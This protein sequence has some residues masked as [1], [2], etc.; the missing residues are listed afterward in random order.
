L[1]R[2]GSVKPVNMVPPMLLCATAYLTAYGGGDMRY[3]YNNARFSIQGQPYTLS[4]GYDVR[5]APTGVPAA[6]TGEFLIF[7]GDMKVARMAPI[8]S[9]GSTIEIFGTLSGL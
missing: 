5:F 6:I 9:G 7:R 2:R 1:W 8:I 3:R 4:G